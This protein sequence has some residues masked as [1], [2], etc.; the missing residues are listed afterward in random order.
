M[1]TVPFDTIHSCQ[2][3]H[4]YL[5]RF[6]R[7]QDAGRSEECGRPRE[8]QH[9]IGLSARGGRGWQHGEAVWPI[10]TNSTASRV[11]KLWPTRMRRLTFLPP[12]NLLAS[13]VLRREDSPPAGSFSINLGYRPRGGLTSFAAVEV[14]GFDKNRY[15]ANRRRP[16]LS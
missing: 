13:L 11:P 15:G 3:A 16:D 7:R 6:V 12:E 8:R 2:A 5:S 4:V 14:C 1:I 10:S 9:H